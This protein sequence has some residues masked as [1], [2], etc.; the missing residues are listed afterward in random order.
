MLA[1]LVRELPVDGF[2]YE[3]KWDGFRAL[4]FRDGE[5]VDLRSRNQRPLARYFPETVEV[6]TR[7]PSAGAVLDGELVVLGD[8]RRFDFPALMARLHPAASRVAKLRAETP[9]TYVVFDLLAEGNETLVDRPFL[10]RRHRLEVLVRVVDAPALALTPMTE[11]RAVAA[12]WLEQFAGG[13]V[14]GV[15]AKPGSMPYRPGR[16]EMLKVK[17]ERTLDCVVGGFRWRWDQ[18]VLGALLLGL[19]EGDALIHI[20]VASSFAERFAKQ[21]LERLA[22]Y[23]TDLQGHPWAFGFGLERSPV[24][25]LAGAAG[26]WAPEEMVMD[27]VPLRPELVCEVAYDTLDGRRLRHPARFRRWR[28]DRDPTSCTFDQLEETTADVVE[29][30]EAS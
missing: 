1:R 17:V 25:R 19:Y 8:D 15:I 4:A 9:A 27:W 2:V 28:P 20:G 10:E 12:G 23:A 24:G 7:L 5:R 16:R 29:L 22:P 18:P 21:V 14:D 6:L 13:G 30:L 3:P 26:R 11:D